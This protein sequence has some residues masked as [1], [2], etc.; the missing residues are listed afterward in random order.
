MVRIKRNKGKEGR[1]KEKMGEQ[2]RKRWENE[3][4]KEGKIGENRESRGK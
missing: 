4:E 1:K 2:S 3:W